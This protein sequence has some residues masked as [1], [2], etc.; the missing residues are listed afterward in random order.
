MLLGNC[1]LDRDTKKHLLQAGEWARVEV[2]SDLD[3]GD[4]R[5]TLFPRIWGRLVKAQAEKKNI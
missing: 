5:A 2:E 4:G 3:G 1:N